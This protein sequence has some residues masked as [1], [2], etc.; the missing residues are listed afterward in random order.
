MD[1]P[2]LFPVKWRRGTIFV[3]DEKQLPFKEEYIAVHTLDEAVEVLR[4]MKT[5]SLGQVL[6]CFYSFILFQRECSIDEICALFKEARPT[7]DFFMLG[8]IIKTQIGKGLPVEAAVEHF[9]YKFD[10][11]RKRRA[12]K[13][14]EILPEDARVLTICNVN[15]ELIYLYERMQKLNKAVIFYVMETRPYLQGTRLT[16]WELRRN[17]I[18]CRLICDSQAAWLM[19]QGEVNCVVCGADRVTV[20]G[21]IINKIGTYA[22]ARLSSH[23]GIP[24]YPLTQ[25]PRDIDIDSIVIEERPKDEAFMFLEGDFS[26]INAFYPAFDITRRDY[27]TRCIEL[28]V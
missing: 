23:F 1:S 25:Y 3:L 21:D 15:G 18:P 28:S 20:K 14:A 11:A 6:L 26:G 9:L 8:K 17:N 12:Q 22:L 24:F 19:K 13:L 2:L 27:I 5:R 16:F 4:D 10:N 7:F